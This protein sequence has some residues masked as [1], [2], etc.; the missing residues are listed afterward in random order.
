MGS[1]ERLGETSVANVLVDLKE[2]SGEHIL[3]LEEPTINMGAGDGEGRGEGQGEGQGSGGE[4]GTRLVA[5]IAALLF[6]PL[7]VVIA[8]GCGCGLL[9]NIVLCCLGWLPGI[10]HAFY[11]V[12]KSQGSI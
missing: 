4:D 3:K 5:L 2:V 9:I 10:I 12:L 6:P 1:V 11:V 8:D 7:G